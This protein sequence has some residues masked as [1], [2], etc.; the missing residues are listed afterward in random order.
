VVDSP[1]CS[2][3]PAVA[4]ITGAGA[5]TSTLTL[6]TTAPT[7]ALNRPLQWIVA[8]ASGV[9]FA[10]M[11]FLGLPGKRA[12]RGWFV[13]L[14][15]AA[16]SISMSGCASGLSGSSGASGGTTVGSYT[17]TVSGVSGAI[18]QSTSLSLTVT[19]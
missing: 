8:P 5:V 1:A 19:N 7:S 16:V 18:A 17:V 12:R 11:C 9:A 4:A 6:A 13:V 14:L 10:C 2:L 15:L 3:S